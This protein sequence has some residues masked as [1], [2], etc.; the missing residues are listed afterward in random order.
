MEHDKIFEN[1]AETKR[2]NPFVPDVVKHKPTLRS[3]CG[4][5]D[6]GFTYSYN[7]GCHEGRPWP[8]W[9]REI[10]DRLA[11]YFYQT[12]EFALVTEFSSGNASLSNSDSEPAMVENSK[13]VCVSLG[14]THSL[15]IWENKQRVGRYPIKAGSIYSM[16][17]EFQKFLR[18]GIA[19]AV[20]NS[21]VRII[22]TFRHLHKLPQGDRV[23]EKKGNNGK[24]RKKSHPKTTTDMDGEVRKSGRSK[25]PT[26]QNRSKRDAGRDDTSGLSQ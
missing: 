25:K 3:S 22:I 16:E 18:H 2:N 1:Y 6:P 8:P 11:R 21:G 13:V 7:G 10:R 24:K 9:L 20:N 15:D 23:V 17:G 12:F 19:Q 5:S 4:F 14:Q 26:H